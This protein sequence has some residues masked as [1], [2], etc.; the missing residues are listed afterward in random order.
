VQTEELGAKKLSAIYDV[1]DEDTSHTFPSLVSTKI[2]PQPE[3]TS[4]TPS[5]KAPANATSLFS[6]SK[7]V[8]FTISASPEFG[9]L[10]TQFLTVADAAP[11]VGMNG[12]DTMTR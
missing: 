7:T 10:D 6:R 8:T 11:A 12:G 2:S 9:I 3:M 4:R 5:G 1:G